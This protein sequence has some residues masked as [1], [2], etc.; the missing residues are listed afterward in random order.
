MNWLGCI[1]KYGELGAFDFDGCQEGAVYSLRCR[2]YGFDLRAKTEVA[3]QA[4]QA[5][6]DWDETTDWPDVRLRRSQGR[7]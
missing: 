2:D 1:G 5:R 6:N 3:F 7:R 4:E